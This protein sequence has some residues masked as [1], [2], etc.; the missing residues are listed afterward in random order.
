MVMRLEC[1]G[2]HRNW[3][4]V[5]SSD[6]LHLAYIKDKMVHTVSKAVQPPCQELMVSKNNNN[7]LYYY[8]YYILFD[9]IS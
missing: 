5:Q 1:G 3:D 9:N 7:L 4:F 8:I 6:C 2:G